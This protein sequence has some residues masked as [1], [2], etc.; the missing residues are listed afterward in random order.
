MDQQQ[1]N[2]PDDPIE[3]AF[4]ALRAALPP[5]C[6]PDHVAASILDAVE[7]A[8]QRPLSFKERT[9]NMLWKTRYPSAA[10]AVLV[11]VLIGWWTL[12]RPS[13]AFAD[14]LQNMGEVRTATWNSRTETKGQPPITGRALYMQPGLM[15]IELDGPMKIVMITN[16]HEERGI[17]LMPDQKK[18]IPMDFRGTHGQAT[19]P[20]PFAMAQVIPPGAAELLGDEEV[21]GHKTTVYRAKLED[22]QATFWADAR[23]GLPVKVEIAHQRAGQ[24]E[25]R[26]VMTDFHWNPKLDE[27]LFSLTTP[28]G[29]EF[30][31]AIDYSH[32][33]E[34]DLVASLRVW[35]ELSDGQ[36]PTKLSASTLDEFASLFIKTGQKG[37]E[38]LK[39][40]MGLHQN[41]SR[42]IMFAMR[43]EQAGLD[44]HYVGKGVKLGEADKPVAWWKAAKDAPTYRVLYG[45]LTI[46]DA[47]AEDLPKAP[48]AL[49]DH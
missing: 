1:K 37:P 2:Q 24:P 22:Q 15:R 41:F 3:Q 35:T 30:M 31:Q 40:F 44:W 29:Y 11:A 27:S 6:L 36:F 38:A 12:G 18:A 4:A 28:E 42:G 26:T 45:D 8:A 39:K 16:Y 48:P 5:D 33:G 23:T 7:R 14:V 13:I 21:D 17:G 49:N 34:H 25:R 46:K 47:K 32:P 19:P 9:L 10:A 20:D 43:T